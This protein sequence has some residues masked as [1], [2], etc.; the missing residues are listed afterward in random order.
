MTSQRFSTLRSLTRC[1]V[2]RAAEYLMTTRGATTTLDVKQWLR[3]QGYMALQQDV[4]GWMSRLADDRYWLFVSNGKFRMYFLPP[5]AV[6]ETALA[7][8]APVREN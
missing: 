6:G 5:P 1:A 3:S 2:L 4:S 8:I 7:Y